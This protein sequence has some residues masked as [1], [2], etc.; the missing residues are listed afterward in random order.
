MTN[1]IKKAVRILV[2]RGEDMMD[3]K[4]STIATMANV[5][6]KDV[7]MQMSDILNYEAHLIG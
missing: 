2:K 5:K 6:L 4:P 1:S 7:K 3:I